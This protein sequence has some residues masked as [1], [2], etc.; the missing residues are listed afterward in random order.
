MRLTPKGYAKS[1]ENTCHTTTDKNGYYLFDN[2]K[3][4]VYQVRLTLPNERQGKYYIFTTKGSESDD[5]KIVSFPVD[6]RLA[7]NCD[8][9][10]NAAIS[11]SC[12]KIEGDSIDAVST[13]GMLT[14]LLLTLLGGWILIR[15]EEV[16][17]AA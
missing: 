10:R 12:V 15:R 8:A 11:C 13:L 1:V 4:D 3:P 2:L 5:K 6:A 14:M 9:E 16:A 17:A 7:A